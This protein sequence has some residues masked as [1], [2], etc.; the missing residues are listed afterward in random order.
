MTTKN[1]SGKWHLPNDQENETQS[2]SG[3]LRISENGVLTLEFTLERDEPDKVIPGIEQSLRQIN[4]QVPIPLIIGYAKDLGTNNDIGF[5][6]YD[7]EIIGYTSSGL[8][9]V[10]LEVRYATTILQFKKTEG[11]QFQSSMMKFEGMDEWLDKNGFEIKSHDDTKQYKTTVE[12]TQP[13]PIDILKTKSEQ[14][15]F[16]FRASSPMFVNTNRVT[17]DQSIFVNWENEEPKSL[18]ELVSYSDRLQNFFSF[19]STYPARRIRHQIRLLRGK[20]DEEKHNGF[21]DLEF[22][23][24]DRANQFRDHSKKSD[25]LFTYSTFGDQSKEILANWIS[26][27]D[28]FTIAFDQYFD[29][30]Y[31]QNLH[32]TSRLITLTSILEIVY[33]R[34]FDKDPNLATKLNYFVTNKVDVFGSLPISKGNMVEQIVAVRRYFV[35][36][37][38]SVHFSEENIT[39]RSM[40]K[41]SIQLE[42]V[43]RIYILSELGIS[44]TDI[45]KIINNQP[46]KWGVK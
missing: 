43:F 16:Y 25:L 38:T 27:Y 28:K 19:I 35:H 14:V 12:F 5:S 22:Y 40:I 34:L 10:T 37:K 41:F 45:T 20:Y 4:N 42:N 17:I 29:M 31:N 13:K 46:W 36:G 3:I 9:H 23:Y 30:K 32:V 8:T 24:K 33:I 44:D 1:F 15:Y 2:F 26:I 21:I 39:E 7:L 18:G 11:L 6:L